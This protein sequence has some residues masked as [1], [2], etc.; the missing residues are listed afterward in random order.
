MKDLRRNWL[1][2]AWIIGVI[3]GGMYIGSDTKATFSA[4]LG[5]FLTYAYMTMTNP[6]SSYS[7]YSRGDKKDRFGNWIDPD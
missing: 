4:L 1:G 2:W 7:R 6:H 5:A 3:G